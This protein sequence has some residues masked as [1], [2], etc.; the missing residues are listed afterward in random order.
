MTFLNYMNYVK[1]LKW[2]ETPDYKLCRSMF[3][4]LYESK[5]YP[6]DFVF[7]WHTHREKTLREKEKAEKEAIEKREQKMQKKTKQVK[8]AVGKR[9]EAIEEA[10]A[11]LEQQE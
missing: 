7:D 3:D 2:D 10:K 6:H 1:N 4:D 9:Q 11:M 8:A 5:H